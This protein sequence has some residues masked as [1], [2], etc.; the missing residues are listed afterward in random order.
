MRVLFIGGTGNISSDCA[1]LLHG[2]GHEIAVVSRGTAPVPAEYRALRADR[3]D[4]QQVHS[5]L[6]DW[7]P[8]VVIN[9]IGY[10]VADVQLDASLLLGRVRQYIFISST[11]VHEHPPATLPIRENSPTGN[12]WWEYARKKAQCEEW[13]LARWH[14]EQFPVTIVRPSH[15][16]SKRWIP[17]AISSSSHTF[18]DRLERGLPVFVH[19]NGEVPW[20]L[21]AAS[22]F[23]IGLAGLI[24]RE[25]TRGE[26]FHITSDEVLTWNEIYREI[27]DALGV[28][29][30]VI[31]K[32][33]TELICEVAPQLTG[34]LKGDKAHPGIFDNSK[35]KRFVPEFVC[36]KSFRTGIRESVA[37]MREEPSRRKVDETVNATIEKI[38]AAWNNQG[39]PTASF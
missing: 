27:A 5:A 13:L 7:E 37:W 11:T 33:P 14:A 8:E 15:T 26:A 38:L 30:P 20:T 3:K 6:A 2:R 10:D 29:S 36:Q 31:Y 24:G 16:Y 18:A 39:R 19:G 17:N 32:I 25:D 22:D 4:A 23:A 12:A 1:A 21:T 28:S 9:F 35:L 34:T